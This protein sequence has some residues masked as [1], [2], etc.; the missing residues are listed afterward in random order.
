MNTLTYL[1]IDVSKAH[2]DLADANAT[3]R[4]ANTP[5]AIKELLERLPKDTHLLVEASGGYERPLVDACHHAAIP[6]S[7][8]NPTR[9]RRFAQARGQYAKT[10]RIDARL[11]HDYGR[12]LHPP[13]TLPA[14]PATRE[15]AEL[16]NARQQLVDARITVLGCLEH[17]SHKTVLRLYRSQ[18]LTLD[19]QIRILQ[20]HINA[21]LTSSPSLRH[22]ALLLQSIKGI[23]PIIAATLLAHLP[24]L[25]HANR[26][27]IAAL[28]GLAPFNSDS[29]QKSGRRFIKGG[30]PKVRRALYL[31][32]LS[33]LR[34][35]SNP[36]CLFY[37]NLRSNGKPAKLALIATARKLL[38]LL[39][40][41]LKSLSASPA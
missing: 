28:A 29:G 40:S 39:N 6:I 14:D 8:L 41:S 26:Q 37:R 30:R 12:T 16:V 25:G 22:K 1:G 9:V 21:L 7:V 36:L 32:A 17:A 2:L 38:S 19:R 5:A 3:T 18:L 24:E 23:G 4:I 20:T 34:S 11:L 27:Q 35:P 31:A 10:D 15:L 33:L 13:A